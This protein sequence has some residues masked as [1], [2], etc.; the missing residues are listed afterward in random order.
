MICVRLDVAA[1]RDEIRGVMEAY[2]NTSVRHGRPV[3][4]R[5]Q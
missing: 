5:A 4:R 1:L 3:K 2:A